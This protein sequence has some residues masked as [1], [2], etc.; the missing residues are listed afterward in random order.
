MKTADNVTEDKKTALN[1][2]QV[3]H[4]VKLKWYDF[5]QRYRLSL[6]KPER[7]EGARARKAHDPFTIE[8]FYDKL[9]VILEETQLTNKPQNIWNCDE[10]GFCS[11]PGS[12]R[13]ICGNRIPAKRITEGNDQN[14]TTVSTCVNASGQ[15]LPPTIIYKEYPSLLIYDGHALH[16]EV[17]LIKLA[18]ANDMIILKL[19][20]HILQPLDV[21]TLE[22]NNHKGIFKKLLFTIQLLLV[23]I[24]KLSINPTIIQ[25]NY[26][27]I[28]NT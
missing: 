1:Y 3:A 15:Y 23:L 20:F 18:V 16:I 7:V 22:K 21:E 6:K 28:D 5:K 11:V 12:T 13:V 8:D 19:P 17:D 10:S 14:M 24:E 4:L 9:E 2:N 26:G 27:D 25:T